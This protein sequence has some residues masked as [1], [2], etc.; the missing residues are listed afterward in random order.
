MERIRTA[1]TIPASMPANLLLLLLFGVHVGAIC[2]PMCACSRGHRVVDC[3]AR[4]LGILPDSLQHNIHFLNLSHNR[5]QDLDGFLVHFDHLRTLDI[6]YNYLNHF[7]VGLPRSLWDV[8]ASGNYIR[9]LVKNDTAYHWNLQSL[10][11]SH[12]QLERV[13]FI[14]NTL[15]SLQALNLSYNKFWTVP[16]NMP[17]NLEIVDLSHN[18]LLQILPGSLDRLLRLSR[19]YLHGNRFTLLS[20]DT[21]S[22]LEGLQL[23]TLG[24]NPWACEDE[25]NINHLMTW[26]QQTH[27]KVLGCPCYT[28]PTCGEVHLSTSRTWHSAAFTEPPLGAD[29]R[30]PGY[31]APMQAV[32][33]GYMSK[34]AL[35]NVHHNPSDINATGAGE[36]ALTM[37][38]GFLTS[39]PHTLST[40]ASTTIRTRSTKK[41]LPGRAQS[42]SHQI[43]KSISENAILSLLCTAMIINAL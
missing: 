28:R 15:S 16:T 19:F 31:Q 20:E 2:P 10:D 37:G 33:S 18:F 27:A 25:E 22:R 42:T 8:R 13:V 24:D 40:H 36:Q 12:N 1:N 9:Q 14:N 7:P 6:S 39:T 5:L 32:T 30:N 35:L 29:S 34:S 11:L 26:M 43:H 4:G 17:Y 23:L 3:S 38:G 41:V 21:F